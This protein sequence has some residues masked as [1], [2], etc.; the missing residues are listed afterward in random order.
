M[1][2]LGIALLRLLGRLPLAWSRAIGATLGHALFLLARKR[3][4]IVLINLAAC[5]P[6][7]DLARRSALARQ[8]F[9]RFAQSWVDRGWLWEGNERLLRE[10]LQLCGRVDQLPQRH[11]RLRLV[12]GRRRR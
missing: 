4:R 1:S 7:M 11:L 3:R 12:C 6:D 5:F 2:R 10:R 8:V 9:V